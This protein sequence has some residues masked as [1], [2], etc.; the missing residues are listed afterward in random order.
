LRIGVERIKTKTSVT[1]AWPGVPRL[2]IWVY[3]HV[4]LARTPAHINGQTHEQIYTGETNKKTPLHPYS[5]V[6]ANARFIAEM[7]GSKW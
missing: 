3:S 2:H 6:S 4:M 7:H 5:C 1:R